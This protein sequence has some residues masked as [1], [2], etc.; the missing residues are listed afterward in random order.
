MNPSYEPS[1]CP[2]SASFAARVVLG[3]PVRRLFLKIVLA[4]T[5]CPPTKT[6][7]LGTTNR[8][9]TTLLETLAGALPQPRSP[10]I[11]CL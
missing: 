9:S 1:E 5:G 8:A 3:Q 6:E 4:D 10:S 7:R 2:P 11:Y